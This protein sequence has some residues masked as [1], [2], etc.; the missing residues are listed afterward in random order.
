MTKQAV[1]IAVPSDDPLK[2]EDGKKEDK[3]DALPLKDKNELVRHHL[4]SIY[5]LCRKDMI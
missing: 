4:I 2:K 5:L 1:V 3:M